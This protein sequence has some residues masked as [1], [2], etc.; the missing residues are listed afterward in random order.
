MKITTTRPAP[1]TTAPAENAPRVH[2]A[3]RVHD[4]RGPRRPTPTTPI[5]HDFLV[6]NPRPDLVFDAHTLRMIATR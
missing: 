2:P 5:T 6:P 3:A 4:V 1:V